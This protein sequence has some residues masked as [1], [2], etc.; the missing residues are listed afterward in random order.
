MYQVLAAGGLPAEPA[1]AAID[2]E[3]ADALSMPATIVA[4]VL[5]NNLLMETPC[6]RR[7]DVD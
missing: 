6:C 7:W 1:V 3:S 4:P 5:F 2:T